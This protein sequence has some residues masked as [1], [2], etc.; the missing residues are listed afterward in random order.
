MEEGQPPKAEEILSALTVGREIFLDPFVALYLD[1]FIRGENGTAG[2]KVKFV[3]SN[4]GSGG[5]THLLRVIAQEGRLR[6][7]QSVYLR[8]G[9][10]KL[11]YIHQ[12]YAAIIGSL[13]LE[14]L[15]AGVR[16]KVI[17]KLGYVPEEIPQSFSFIAWAE[18]KG[19]A[20]E[21]VRK[22]LRTEL[23][24]FL[25]NPRMDR[26]FSLALIQIVLGDL[27]QGSH[28]KEPE[29][30]QALLDW[31]SA[32]PELSISMLRR[33]N[34]FVRITRQNA[35]R[36]LSSLAELTRMA[37]FS[38]LVVCLDEMDDLLAPKLD[39]RGTKY[40]KMS[41]ED[42]F[43]SLRELID[44]QE[45]LQSMLFLLAARRDLLDDEK[46][47]LKSYPALWNRIREEI[48]SRDAFNPYV[49][50]IDLDRLWSFQEKE[51][52]TQHLGESLLSLFRKSLPNREF[53]GPDPETLNS[54]LEIH[55][56]NV[57]HATRIL[58]AH[59][60]RQLR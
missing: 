4:E 25:Q 6:N 3:T 17:Q 15:L 11:H 19:E 44:D 59:L 38:G 54:V 20:L 39:G 57:R 50:L 1:R 27:E 47:G 9:A 56:F 42:T 41:R 36:M 22:G 7:Y 34:I 16:K 12:F 45:N 26:N 60:R 55:P 33:E 46:R 43:E 5:K 32:R 23:G 31:F 18:Q 14:L 8:A 51:N 24:R 29:R 10:F 35:R 52:I 40:T 37:G 49:D 58:S 53:H 30:R 48:S 13:D 21:M 28:W 2:S